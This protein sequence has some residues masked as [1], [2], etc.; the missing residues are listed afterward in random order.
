MLKTLSIVVAALMLAE[1]AQS[2]ETN[3]QYPVRPLRILTAE[4]GGAPDV[5]LRLMQPAWT[6]LLGQQFVVDNRGGG[7]GLIA[8]QTVSR[9]AADGYTLL[10]YAAALWLSPLINGSKEDPLKDFA[11][12]SLVASQPNILV[13]HPSLPVKS[14]RELIAFAKAR[15]GQL[16]YGSGGVGAS[17]H[18]AGELFNA[19]AGVNIVRIAYKGAGPAVNDLLGGHLQLMFASTTSI[20]PHVASGRVR[21]LAVTSPQPSALAP[22]LPTVTSAG[23]PGFETR[24]LNVMFAPVGTPQAII[25][26][27][28]QQIRDVVSR[29][30]VKERFLAAGL[31]PVGSTADEL[32][33][34]LKSDMARWGKLVREGRIRGES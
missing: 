3:P 13:V 4:A 1:A 26:L 9:S 12:I 28:Y 24:G 20:A 2:A 33:A 27:L 16:N 15:P 7:N 19:M 10:F 8:A 30:A 5:A 23:L 29:P 21:A 14:V 18:L 11:P 32:S 25:N 34:V 22:G 31:E 17:N 6:E